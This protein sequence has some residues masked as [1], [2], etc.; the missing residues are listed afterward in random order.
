MQPYA[1][2]L[3]RDFATRK[4]AYDKEEAATPS[5]GGAPEAEAVPEH[6]YRTLKVV[7][8]KDVSDY[9]VSQLNEIFGVFGGA[10]G[11]E[12]VVIRDGKKKKGSALVVFREVAH[13]AKA[14]TAQCGKN[15]EEEAKERLQAELAVG[16]TG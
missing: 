1:A 12:D 5:S 14:A 2:R 8:R 16:F 10:A 4:K 3:R 7:W 9:K 13:A 15:E 11:V 6:M